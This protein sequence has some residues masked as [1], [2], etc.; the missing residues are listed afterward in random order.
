MKFT[1]S[2]LKDHLDTGASLDTIAQTL[3]RI[4]LEVEGV[5]DKA[6][7]LKPYV[8][9][10]ILS[11]EQHPNA[12]RLRVCSVD[13]G[14]GAP[15]Q[16]VCGA[17]NARAGLVSV[18]APPGTYVPGKDITLA[19][20]TI[21]G[22]ESRGMLCS[23]AE[24]GLGDDHDGIMELPDDAPVGRPYALYA[25][26]DDPV[27]E[28]NLT[29]NRPDCTAVS[30]IAR[31]LAATGLG[32][33]TREPSKPVRGE[34]ACTVPV[35]L[36]FAPE[37]RGLCPLFAVRLVRGVSNGP[38]PDWMQARL[39]AIGLRPINALVDI[40]N[41]LTFDRGRPL[42][43]FDAAKVQGGLEV[44]LAREGEELKALDG[45]TY[46][47][48]PEMVII[49]D[50]AGPES[51]GGIIGGEAT[52]CDAGTVDVLVEAALWDPVNIA[53]TGRRLGIVTDA[54]YRFERGVD[55][56]FA[57]PGLDLATRMIL[58]L[59]GGTAGEAL[60]FGEP[61]ETDQIIDFPW[62]ETR[63]LAG[64]ELSRAEMKVTLET[65]GFHVSGS[66]DRV[67][68]LP[69]S[70]R[71][72]IGGKADLV[73]E[74]IRIAG[75][76]QIEAKPLP[77]APSVGKP[78][79]TVLQRRTRHAKRALAGR[80]L[81][82][83][84]TWS[85]IGHDD[86]VLFG[87]GGADLALANPIAADLSDMRPSLVPGLARA[88]QRNADRGNGDVALFEVGQCFASDQPEGQT[89]RAA[90]LRR[91]TAGHAGA[92]R[93]WDGAAKAVDAFD[94]KADAMALLASLGV[95]V[96]GLQVVTG[97]PSW[98]HPGR[99]G[100][101]QFG[102][103]IVVGHFGE[104]HPRAMKA[105]D[106]KGQVV[107]FEIVLDA[108]PLPKYR[109]TKVKPALALSD[110]QPISRDFA[111]VVGRDVAAGDIVKAAQGAERKL[112]TGIDVFDLYEGVGIPEGA[113]SVAI[114][115]RL[116]PSERTL[117]D[118]EIEAVS[119]RIV[120]EVARKTGAT[121]RS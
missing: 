5:E 121:L 52:G 57:L 82:E 20:G 7:A 83:A 23:G 32:S 48:E 14:D 6:A 88:A 35:T 112:I 93:H 109:P 58:D 78:A 81:V 43:V 30:G 36:A 15:V 76:D 92:G 56:A 85:F 53:R 74:I 84:V 71:P 106:L 3:T 67:K 65:L 73:E 100:T 98:L 38:S 16:V 79:L 27:I 60:V 50:A 59:C 118:A 40:T 115:V 110:F 104:L 114:A 41:Y 44:R 4:G 72:D 89:M 111:F 2:W 49:A 55:P 9:A 61:P 24:L 64:M 77:R 69:P 117:T 80:G 68:V 101:L 46:R 103:K 113:K 18:F 91:G 22:V 29:P 19:V 17:P 90:A 13:A 51:I 33:L 26:L 63:R 28:I 37:D 47:L 70:W 108:V 31:D 97:G 95:P 94:A 45:K 1:L 120:A 116:Q 42:H 21:R 12:D 86:A 87:G 102:P 99:C 75:L 10:R 34:G 25:G 107:A 66:G 8:V 11:A 105:L 62:S 54:R 96:G 119:G 39:R